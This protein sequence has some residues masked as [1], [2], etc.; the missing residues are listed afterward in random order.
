M[1][2]TF[3]WYIYFV[4]EYYSKKDKYFLISSVSKPQPNE[5]KKVQLQWNE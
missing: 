1:Y 2:H 4:N 5:I 3:Y